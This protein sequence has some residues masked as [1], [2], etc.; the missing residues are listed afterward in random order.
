MESEH[1]CEGTHWPLRSRRRRLR[2]GDMMAAVATTAVG[3]AAV[4]L[5][6]VTGGG[7]LFVGAFALFCQGLQWAQW[8]LASIPDNQPAITML[9]GALS[10]I[11]AVS[12]FI[13]LVVLGLVFPQVAAIFSVMMLISVVYLTTWG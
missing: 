10:S 6:E 4:I 5:P 11:I 2:I 8:G 3:L 9:L 7:R 13:G 12:L 1:F